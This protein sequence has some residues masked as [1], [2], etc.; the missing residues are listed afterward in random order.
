MQF[1]VLAIPSGARHLSSSIY[2]MPLTIEN[3]IPVVLVT[4]SLPL[5]A[6]VASIETISTM[7]LMMNNDFS[8]KS[9]YM[10]VNKRKLWCQGL[11]MTITLQTRKDNSMHQACIK[12]RKNL[13]ICENTS[14]TLRPA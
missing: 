4:L 13:K 2:Q 10:L 12:Q 6:E 7:A 8:L 9:A 3:A 1:D 5:V 14:F 11:P